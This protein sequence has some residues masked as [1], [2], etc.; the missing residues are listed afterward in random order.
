M[1]R[2]FRNAL[3]FSLP[4]LAWA[5]FIFVVDP[6]AYFSRSGFIDPAVKAENARALNSLL[7]NT[8]EYRSHPAPNIV[9]GDSRSAR[10]PIEYIEELT[11]DDYACISS[12]AAKLNEIIDL[13][14]YASSKRKLDRAYICLNFN[15]YNRFAYAD[16]VDAVRAVE[17]NPLLYLYSRSVAE[18]AVAVLRSAWSGRRAVDTTPPMSPEEF[19]TWM[20]DERATQHYGRYAYP[21]EITERLR[22]V[23]ED[24]RARGTK[25]F[26][27]VVP[28]HRDFRERL[29]N[30]GLE[31]S[32]RRF[33]EDIRA[34]APVFDF[35][36]DNA[37]TASREN[38]G[39]P[40]HMTVEAAHQLVD[41]VWGGKQRFGRRLH[42]ADSV[43]GEGES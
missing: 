17:R 31:E 24:A 27:V 15:M 21:E 14:W 11:G 29:A 37:F 6:F 20:V 18:A 5:A 28:H 23:A 25:L 2:L 30:F 9:L 13:Y 22:A 26:F 16:R 3:L 7:Y 38:F 1:R 42:P 41:E 32:E 10:L 34:I 43:P 12:N 35:D 19:W 33:R 39:D 40:I 36:W 4:L 8:L